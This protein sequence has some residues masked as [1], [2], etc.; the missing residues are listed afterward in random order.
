MEIWDAC[1]RDGNVLGTDIVR[2]ENMP[3]GLY[4]VVVDVVVRHIDGTY[5][6]MQRDFSKPNFPGLWELGASGSI[7]KG[8][9]PQAGAIREL[10]EETG[11]ASDKL[12][13][14]DRC[15]SRNSIYVIFLCVTDAAK[16]SVV[17]QPGETIAFQWLSKDKMLA[18]M[19]TDA[20]VG[21]VRERLSECMRNI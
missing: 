9:S 17:L 13:Q 20:F 5:L 7:L 8:E 16:S 1:D 14:I 21:V 3:D 19:E 11:I 2:G 12:T 4:H 10:R 18:F 15:V 6:L